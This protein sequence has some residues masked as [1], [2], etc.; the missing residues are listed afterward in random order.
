[1]AVSEGQSP[2]HVFKA[3]GFYLALDRYIPAYLEIDRL[4]YEALSLLQEG[5]P[6]QTVGQKL[7]H[8]WGHERVSEM[9]ASFAALK[10]KGFFV[11][12]GLASA[13]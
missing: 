3:D 4:A 1:M 6:E 7:S 10:Q 5:V 2:Y 13:G 9:F 11:R 8:D 12:R